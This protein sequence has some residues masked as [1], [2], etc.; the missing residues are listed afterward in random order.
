MSDEG[1]AEEIWN[2]NLCIGTLESCCEFHL[3][4]SDVQRIL[5][6][7]VEAL[8]QARREAFEEAAKI[9]DGWHIKKGG[10]GNLAA[11]IR[12]LGERKI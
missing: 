2:K 6:D 9:V 12:D 4:K 7:F 10:Y 1:K 11:T 3:K 5:K 8:R